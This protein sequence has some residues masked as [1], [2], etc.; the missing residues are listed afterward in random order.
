MSTYP[1]GCEYYSDDW[2]RYK[3]IECDACKNAKIEM[4]RKRDVAVAKEDNRCLECVKRDSVERHFFSKGICLKH[5]QDDLD[6]IL[7][8]YRLASVFDMNEI[9]NNQIIDAE[10]YKEHPKARGKNTKV[11]QK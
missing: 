2:N 8:Q 6:K 5:L 9:K 10:Y 3:T 11:F 1:C 7:K 4:R